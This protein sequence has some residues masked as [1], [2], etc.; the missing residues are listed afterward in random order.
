MCYNVSSGDVV[1]NSQKPYMKSLINR[2]QP[3]DLIA[4]VTVLGGM[5]L[6]FAGVDGTVGTIMTMVVAWYF[7]EKKIREVLSAQKKTEPKVQSV[8]DQIRDIARSEGVD[9]DLAVRVARCESGFNPQAVNV[10]ESGSKDRGVFQWNDK[11]HPEISD[12]CAFDVECATTE[13]CKAVKKGHLSWWNAS[14]KCWANV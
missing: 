3:R 13:F 14:K 7:G 11:W 8:E 4:L 9:P 1:E 6:K 12:K 2:F 5:V 10:N